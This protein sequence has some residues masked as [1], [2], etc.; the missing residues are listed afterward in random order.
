MV[1]IKIEKES[2]KN[3][4]KKDNLKL[5]N[6]E[7]ITKKLMASVVDQRWTDF[8]TIE[9]KMENEEACFQTLKQLDEAEADARKSHIFLMSQGTSV[10]E[11]E[12]HKWKE[13]ESITKA[14]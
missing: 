12:R 6:I 3:N 4:L 9:I 2:L 7:E 10:G 11:V 5:K 1:P 14:H 8:T 13:D